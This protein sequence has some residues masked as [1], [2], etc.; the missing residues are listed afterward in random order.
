MTKKRKRYTDDFRASAVLMLEAAGYPEKPGALSAVSSRLDVPHSTLGRWF[1]ADQN[2][3]PSEL[4]HEKRFDLVQAIRDE[5]AGILGEM[6]NARAEADYR[7][8]ATGFGILTDKLQLLTG[9]ATERTETINHD[10]PR[11]ELA[12]RLFAVAEADK[13][14]S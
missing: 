2:P 9:Q 11:D 1:R 7:A 6:P 13:V 3:P 14:S 4:V 5:L 8:L 10:D 12:R